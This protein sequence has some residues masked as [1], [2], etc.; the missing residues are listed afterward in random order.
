MGYVIDILIYVGALLGVGA[1]TLLVLA[2]KKEDADLHSKGL[3]M[4]IVAVILFG[5]APLAIAVLDGTDL[6]PGIRFFVIRG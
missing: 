6:T 4:F 5:I 3:M 1:I 2:F